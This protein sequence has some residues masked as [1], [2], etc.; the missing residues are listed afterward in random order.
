MIT[1]VDI[2]LAVFVLLILVQTIGI[3]KG[4]SDMNEKI[5][6]LI[7]KVHDLTDVVDSAEALLQQLHDML[8]DAQGDPAAIQGVIDML[9]T[10]RAELADAVAA[11]TPGE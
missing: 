5:L 2:A 1:V 11:N 9:E 8:V 3:R 6:A 7:N 4:L 10:Q